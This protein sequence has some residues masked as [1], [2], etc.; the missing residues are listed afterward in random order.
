MATVKARFDGRVFVPEGP[1]NLPV[2]HLLEIGLEPGPLVGRIVREVYE[3]QLDGRV[4]DLPG[5]L[6]EARRL[7]A[8]PG[9]VGG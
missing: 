7:L 4:T 8:A 6:Q 1:V 3:M 9:R 5:A 2:G